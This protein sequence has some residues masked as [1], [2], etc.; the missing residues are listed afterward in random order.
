MKDGDSF[1][2]FDHAGTI[3]PEGLGELGLYH[4][5]TRFLSAFEIAIDRHRPLL[6]GSSVRRDDVLVV[7]LANPD[8]TDGET[9]LLR[10]TVHLFSSSFLWDRSWHVR[11]R[12]RSYLPQPLAIELSLLFEA[13]FA[14]IFEVRGVDRIRR[15]RYLDT[16]TTRDRLV[17]GYEGLDRVVR[18]TRLAFSPIPTLMSPRR[19]SFELALDALGEAVIEFRANFVVGPEL[20][21]ELTYDEALGRT[22]VATEDRR[23][24][25]AVIDTT[26]TR[27]DDWLERS[28][29][30]LNMMI[31]RT[32][33]GDYPYAGVPWFSTEFGRD[34]IIT[35]FETLWIDPRLARG[36]LAFL[37]AT[38]AAHSSAEQ[39]AEPGKIIHEIRR[40]E[41]AALGEIPFGRY[42]GSVDS[43]PLFI[44]LASAYWR[45]SG[46]RAFITTLWPHIE[47][48][49]AW[50][51]EHGDLDGDGFVEYAR[52]A[53]SGLRSQ[54]WKDSLDS[55]SHRNGTLADG[56]VALCEVQGYVYAAK[57][58]AAEIARM[59]GFAE[60]AVQLEREADVLRE[61]FERAYWSDELGT[62]VLAL[63]GDKRP[64]EVVSSNAGHCLFAGICD[65]AR[66][67]R[68][69]DTLLD[70]A[71]YSGWGIRTLAAGAA[72]YNPLSYHNG[73]VWPHDNAMIAMGMARYGH[74]HATTRILSGLLDSSIE[75]D[76]RRMPELFCGFRRRDDAGPTRYPVACAPQAWAAGAVFMLLQACLGLDIDAAHSRIVL[77][78]PSL[79]HSLRRVRVRNLRVGDAVT[80]LVLDNY[81]HDVGVHLERRDG[82]LEVVTVK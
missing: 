67:R 49:L 42:Y 63:D 38:Q 74:K 47:R 60:R 35:A 4:Q 73:S 64:C 31:T 78:R 10:D 22:R 53:S 17:L 12:L 77:D 13:D 56:P 46:D 27:F 71:S 28:A 72:R 55:I 19:V 45:R 9:P 24:C 15:G 76:L 41:M 20:P 81:D 58:G 1:G 29:S 52:R 5:G 66:A 80:D 82:D 11:L 2:V 62:Y 44:M 18:T 23:R 48:A 14:D 6:L 59:L 21:P 16:V 54:G 50:I 3:R 57:R 65:P 25:C 75:F 39:D 30:D 36:V 40:G 37:A 79:P 43:T 8:I 68:V 26:N 32:P 51:E 34:G 69:V 70:D 7:D 33:H 61:Q